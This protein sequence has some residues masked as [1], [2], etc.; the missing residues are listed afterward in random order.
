MARRVCRH[1]ERNRA[2]GA[3][4]RGDRT[5]LSKTQQWAPADCSG[6]QAA[7]PLHTCEAV[8]DT[9]TLLKFRRLR[10]TYKQRRAIVCRGPLVASGQGN[11]AHAW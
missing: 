6:A 8:P 10:E 9:T 7:D 3:A 1:D 5:A 4:M 11:E 2:M